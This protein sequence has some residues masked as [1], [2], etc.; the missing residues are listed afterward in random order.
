MDL[1]NWTAITSVMMDDSLTYSYS[2]KRAYK[3]DTVPG[4]KGR[5]RKRKA[6]KVARRL[7][8]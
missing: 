2:A 6:Q 4:A 8:R 1:N 3:L 7:N 5:R